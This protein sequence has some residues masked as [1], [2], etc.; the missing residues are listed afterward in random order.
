[1]LL[2]SRLEGTTACRSQVYTKSILPDDLSVLEFDPGSSVQISLRYC[3]RQPHHW[4]GTFN[5]KLSL[6]LPVYQSFAFPS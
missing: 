5:Y 4:L 3:G 6:F 1:M 2:R